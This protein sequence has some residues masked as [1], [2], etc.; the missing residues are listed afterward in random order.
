MKPP[1]LLLAL[2]LPGFSLAANPPLPG[3]PHGQATTQGQNSQIRQRPGKQPEQRIA[4]GVLPDDS[5]FDRNTLTVA[6]GAKVTLLFYNKGDPRSG[7]EHGWLL[8]SVG[9]WHEVG[10]LAQKAGPEKGYIPDSPDVIA[11]TRVIKPGQV[12]TLTFT[13]PSKP[14][15]YMFICPVYPEKMHG[16]LIV[17]EPKS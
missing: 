2:L 16:M 6:A 8:T 15:H 5:D 7:K 9:K 3:V 14:G 4:I 13:A 11:H 12:D 10:K 17:T 1:V